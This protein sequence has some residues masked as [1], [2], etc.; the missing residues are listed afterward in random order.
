MSKKEK[1]HDETPSVLGGLKAVRIVK[2]VSR[3][4]ENAEKEGRRGR[5]SQ[6]PR[7]GKVHAFLN[8]HSP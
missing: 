7:L 3:R 5:K 6:N 4:A 8:H 2:Y 1:F